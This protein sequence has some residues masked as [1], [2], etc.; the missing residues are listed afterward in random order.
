M[1]PVPL[2]LAVGVTCLAGCGVK[3]ALY[4]PEKPSEVIIRPAPGTEP[5]AGRPAAPPATEPEEPRD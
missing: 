2:L 3:G 1:R 4:L 5:T